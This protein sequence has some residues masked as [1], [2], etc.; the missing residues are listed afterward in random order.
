[1]SHLLVRADEFA[2]VFNLDEWD[3]AEVE[4]KRH[5]KGSLAADEP[6][7]DFF[8]VPD[9]EGPVTPVLVSTEQTDYSDD[10]Y[11]YR[12]TAFTHEG[13]VLGTVTVQID[14]RS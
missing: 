8:Y 1:M 7:G 10:D 3:R 12:T 4:L 2:G 9:Y 13:T 11:A 14:G 6:I 5:I